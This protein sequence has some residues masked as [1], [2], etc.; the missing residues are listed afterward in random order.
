MMETRALNSVCASN[1]SVD[2]FKTTE[3]QVTSRPTYSE[4]ED[5]PTFTE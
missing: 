2:L 1:S 3:A 4:S 5:G